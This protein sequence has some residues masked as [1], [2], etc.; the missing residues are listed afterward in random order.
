MELRELK[1]NIIKG[2][3]PVD[4]LIFKIEDSSYI[5]NQYIDELAKLNG[6]TI[7]Y[8]ENIDG[9][10]PDMLFS[11]TNYLNVIYL[12]KL[13]KDV[14][15]PYEIKNGIIKCRDIDKEVEK[16]LQDYIVEFKNPTDWQ[17]EF[18]A[19]KLLDG[20]DKQAI[21]WLCKSLKGN[22]DRLLNEI[23]KITNFNKQDR[24]PIFLQM[25]SDGQFD[26]ISPYSIFHLVNNIV[27]RE[28]NKIKEILPYIK[29]MDVEPYALL[30]MLIKQFTLLIGVSMGNNPT[31]E[32]LEIS[33]K[34]FKAISYNK[35]RYNH[36][37]LVEILRM[38]T[39]IDYKIKSGYLD[40]GQVVDYI[41]CNIM[42]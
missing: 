15:E 28:Y 34:Q 36:K 7:E 2:V 21:T 31:P 27:K 20:M 29:Y 35:N 22:P 23:D 40:Y 5:A 9:L 1:E 25:D 30:T 14:K 39:S 8:I 12:D 38:L 19:N 26:D 18:R 6:L 10:Y 3:M 13:D 24:M 11:N 32:K 16:H 37:E 33:D 41:I 17:L 42:R 4:F